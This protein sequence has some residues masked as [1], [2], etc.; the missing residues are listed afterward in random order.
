MRLCGLSAEDLR[1]AKQL[2]LNPRSLI[3]SRPAK[4]QRWKAPVQ[5]WIR[6][7]YDRML[8]R[9]ARKR[10]RKANHAVLVKA[11]PTAV[12]D[13]PAAPGSHSEHHEAAFTSPG[14]ERDERP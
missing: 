11:S 8:E 10:E 5:I 14:L 12:R 1:K 2:G 13:L 6:D 9:S 3:K 7:L 4:S